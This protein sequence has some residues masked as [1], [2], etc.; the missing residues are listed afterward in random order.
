[1]M[2]MTIKAALQKLI[3]RQDLTHAE[4]L[5]LMRQV[6]QGDFTPAQIAGLLIGLRVKIE[7]VDE[8]AA[9]A[10]VMREL[11]STVNVQNSA[12]LVDTCGTGGAAAGGDAGLCQCAGKPL[13]GRSAAALQRSAGRAAHHL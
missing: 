6:M 9:A 11:V 2:E 1:M 13:A 8:I 3:Q 10:Q 5:S 12:N 7:T 4:M